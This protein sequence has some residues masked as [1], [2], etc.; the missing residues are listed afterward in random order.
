[1]IDELIPLK[2]ALYGPGG[3]F[4]AVTYREVRTK[5][6]PVVRWRPPRAR[7]RSEWIRREDLQRYLDNHS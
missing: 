6:G 3:I 7:M 5:I 2:L 1:M 4:P